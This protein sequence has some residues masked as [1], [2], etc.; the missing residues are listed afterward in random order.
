LPRIRE[1]DVDI[2]LSVCN[3][4]IVREASMPDEHANALIEARTMRKPQVRQHKKEN[5][6][7]PALKGVTLL[8][9][10]K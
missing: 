9:R 1:T 6:P 8:P 4:L 2:G 7:R 3:D 5:T 10:G